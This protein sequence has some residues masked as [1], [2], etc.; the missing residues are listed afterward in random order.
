MRVF[1]LP[2]IVCVT[3]VK[4]S[5]QYD[6][7]RTYHPNGIIASILPLYQERAEGTARFYYPDGTLQEERNY[8]GGKVEGDVKRYAES[9]KLIEMFTIQNGKRDGQYISFDSAGAIV[10]DLYYVEGR[11]SE[12]G[13]MNVLSAPE[14]HAD[15]ARSNA[16]MQQM[17]NPEADDSISVEPDSTGFIIDLTTGGDLKQAG[18]ERLPEPEGGWPMFYSRLL[19]P[20]E[21]NDRNISGVVRLQA[22][23]DTMGYVKRTKILSGIGYGCDQM[24]DILVYFTKFKPPVRNNKPFSCTIIMDI[25]FTRRR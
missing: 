16:D 6:T 9:G 24:A 4:V 21:A 2:V 5:A 11:I 3:C 25:V 23:L 8:L 12:D 7:L 15:T 1:I 20:K 22:V 14:T 17:E 18:I 10:N 19:Y 13:R